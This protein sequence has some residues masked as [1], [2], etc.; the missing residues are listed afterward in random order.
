MK[1]FKESIR[2]RKMAWQNQMRLLMG[3]DRTVE[4]SEAPINKKA[5]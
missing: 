1:L 4:W 2:D 3:L 5:Q